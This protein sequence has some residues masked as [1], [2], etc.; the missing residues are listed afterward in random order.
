MYQVCWNAW[1]AAFWS[2]S[3][4]PLPAE[5]ASDSKTS[6]SCASASSKRLIFETIRPDDAV[7]AVGPT[8]FSVRRALGTALS[9]P[10]W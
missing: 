8:P 3:V 6:F 10:G 4:P 5:E 2:V 9:S 7:W 1:S